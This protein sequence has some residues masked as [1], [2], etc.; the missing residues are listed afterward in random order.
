MVV[1]S[2]EVPCDPI[3]GDLHRWMWS[4]DQAVGGRGTS[5]SP[6]KRNQAPVSIDVRRIDEQAAKELFPRAGVIRDPHSGQPRSGD[7]QTS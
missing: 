3:A 6:M 4:D 1:S 2:R 5:P 7:D